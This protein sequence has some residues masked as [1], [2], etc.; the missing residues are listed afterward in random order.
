MMTSRTSTP[1]TATRR[2]GQPYVAT[3]L[4]VAGASMLAAGIWAG[5][6]PG[7]FARFV[8]FPLPRALP[9]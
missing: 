2:L 9:A 5:A 7:S 8:V 4:A 1:V 6:A 3:I